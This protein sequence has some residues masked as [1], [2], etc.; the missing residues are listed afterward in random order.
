MSYSNK[1]N[2][3]ISIVIPVYNGEK[4][5]ERC[6]DSVRR[7]SFKNFEVILV[8]DGSRDM[9]L[10]KMCSYNN[11]DNRFKVISQGNCGP[12]AA[13]NK[14]I[15]EAKGKY[16]IFIDIDDYISEFYLEKSILNMKENTIVFS[17]VLEVFKDKTEKRKVFSKKSGELKKNE[18][19]ISILNGEGGLVCGK[20]ID[21]NLIKKEKIFFNKKFD[22]CEDQLFFLEVA[23]KSSFFYYEDSYLYFY[24]R[25]ESKS[26]SLKYKENFNKKQIDF[27]N[28]IEFILK[29]NRLNLED[30]LKKIL[31]KKRDSLAE[32]V[33]VNEF[34][35]LSFR[36][37]IDRIKRLLAIGDLKLVIKLFLKF[38][39]TSKFRVLLNKTI[40]RKQYEDIETIK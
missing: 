20:L 23:L 19:L 10:K 32:M 37:C 25:T 22:M 9:S 14:G 13:R 30:D 24:D 1:D 8:D 15:E 21:L 12:S 3:D 34:K 7:Q 6:L 29:K 27:F 2:C 31:T 40:R 28:E 18:A 11:K 5:I 17:N 39:I 38:K 36:N 16:L 26:L 4:Y 35:E 33:I